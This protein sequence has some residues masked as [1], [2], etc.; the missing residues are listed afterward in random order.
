[1]AGENILDILGYQEA[2]RMMQMP[3]IDKNHR[4]LEDATRH[5]DDSVLIC[6]TPEIQLNEMRTEVFLMPDFLEDPTDKDLKYLKEKKYSFLNFLFNNMRLIIDNI[7][8]SEKLNAQIFKESQ[9]L[10][11]TE[12]ILDIYQHISDLVVLIVFVF[13]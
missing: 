8:I 6:E 1:M 9:K 7:H 12:D 13:K 10:K 11:S 4:V 3:I 5:V 2:R